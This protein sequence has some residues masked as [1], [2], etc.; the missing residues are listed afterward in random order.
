GRNKR[1]WMGICVDE[2]PGCANLVFERVVDGHSRF[3][4]DA[5]IIDIRYNPDNATGFRA[6]V[7]ELHDWVRPHQLT[8]EC[9]FTGKQFV[10]NVLADDHNALG[11]ITISFVEIASGDHRNSKSRKETG[12]YRTDPCAWVLL[13]VFARLPGNPKLPTRSKRSRVAPGNRTANGD[14]LNAWDGD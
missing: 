6:H 12:R 7:D 9:V 13:T 10:G 2:Q 5:L 11:A 4:I 1:I 14:A 3:R 8:I